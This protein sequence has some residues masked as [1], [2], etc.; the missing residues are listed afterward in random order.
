VFRG[1][2]GGLGSA[3]NNGVVTADNHTA[4]SSGKPSSETRACRM[5]PHAAVELVMHQCCEIGL[6]LTF[7]FVLA[8][9]MAQ[10]PEGRG[11]GGGGGLRVGKTEW[12]PGCAF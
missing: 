9:D 5:P 1:R 6:M 7:L 4:A 10:P 2:D 8:G 11:G 12:N 3:N